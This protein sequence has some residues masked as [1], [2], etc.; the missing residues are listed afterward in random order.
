MAET[1][2]W[3]KDQIEEWY[4]NLDEHEKNYDDYEAIDQFTEDIGWKNVTLPNGSVAIPEGT[5][6][7]DYESYLLFSVDGKTYAFSGY[8]NSWESSYDA[9]PFEA[10]KTQV[11]VDKWIIK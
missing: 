7:N 2:Q 3:L 9:G 4:E 1:V 10:E 6:T 5:Y 8:D 11:L